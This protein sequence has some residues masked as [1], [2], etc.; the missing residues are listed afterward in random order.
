MNETD[1]RLIIWPN[2]PVKTHDRGNILLVIG[3]LKLY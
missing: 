2:S 3:D 1:S